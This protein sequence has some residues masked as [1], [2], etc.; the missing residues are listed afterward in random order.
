MCE[1]KLLLCVL[2]LSCCARYFDGFT[3]MCRVYSAACIMSKVQTSPIYRNHTLEHLPQSTEPR[4]V[5][6]SKYVMAMPTQFVKLSERQLVV[7][8]A[9]LD[10]PRVFLKRLWPAGIELL[11]KA[12]I[13]GE[14]QS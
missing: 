11:P 8:E 14:L 9:A 4:A 1:W 13:R 5:L 6:G 12:P 10:P 2:L 7:L 3:N